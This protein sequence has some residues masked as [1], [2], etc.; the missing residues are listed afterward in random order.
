M[1]G[2]KASKQGKVEDRKFF[3]AIGWP[4]SVSPPCIS[5]DSVAV[6]QLC[7][8][9][10]SVETWT[11]GFPTQVAAASISAASVEVRYDQDNQ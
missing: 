8:Y 7:L 2:M 11:D 10:T 1:T 5:S 9:F 6:F 4:S 3:G